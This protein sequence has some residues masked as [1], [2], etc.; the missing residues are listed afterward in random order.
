MLLDRIT[1]DAPAHLNP[2][3]ALWLV[4]SSVCDTGHTL[5]SLAAAGLDASVAATA[6]RPAGAAAG[7]P[8][9]DARRRGD[10]SIRSPLEEELV[11]IRAVAA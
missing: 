1:R 10:L 9:T 11:A 2:G 8:R 7:R 3:G 4:H 6:R 5:D